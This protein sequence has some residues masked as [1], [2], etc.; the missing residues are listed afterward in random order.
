MPFTTMNN[1]NWLFDISD[2]SR[3]PNNLPHDFNYVSNSAVTEPAPIRP[4]IYQ[5]IG[6]TNEYG[7][8]PRHAAVDPHENFNTSALQPEA[9][10][11]E[12]RHSHTLFIATLTK[13]WLDSN[14]VRGR[15]W[16]CTDIAR[17]FQPSITN[18]DLRISRPKFYV[19]FFVC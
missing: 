10:T 19:I 2:M 12:Q 3:A 4:E 16:V 9:S 1:Y 11:T 5:N 14:S 8:M 7:Y 13:G 18:Y 17:N 15:V 6:L